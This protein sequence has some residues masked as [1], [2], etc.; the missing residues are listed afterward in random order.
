M[1]GEKTKNNLVFIPYHYF[2]SIFLH[3]LAIN[4]YNMKSILL[5]ETMQVMN[6]MNKQL[7]QL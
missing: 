6:T 2:L 7:I 3:K 4:H 1:I 5:L